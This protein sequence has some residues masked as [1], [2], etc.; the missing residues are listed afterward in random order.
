MLRE[1]R[2]NSNESCMFMPQ[3]VQ[4]GK[5]ATVRVNV[6]NSSSEEIA[7]YQIVLSVHGKVVEEKEINVPVAP[8]SSCCSC[9]SSEKRACSFFEISISRPNTC[10]V[11]FFSRSLFIQKRWSPAII[12]NSGVARWSSLGSIAT[13]A[14]LSTIVSCNSCNDHDYCFSVWVNKYLFLLNDVND[15][16]ILILLLNL[17]GSCHKCKLSPR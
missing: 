16:K 7:P 14:G 2:E 10:S 3:E 9:C 12:D 1:G 15:I 13:T 8:F 6:R 4:R 17:H 5:P 11:S